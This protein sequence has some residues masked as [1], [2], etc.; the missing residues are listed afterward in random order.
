MRDQEMLRITI[1]ETENE[2]RLVVEGQ[3]T[4]SSVPE[5]ESAWKE[6]RKL[7][8]NCAYVIDLS[9]TTCVDSSGKAALIGMVCDGARLIANG[10][11]TEYV[12]QKLMNQAQDARRRRRDIAGGM[13]S[14][15]GCAG[16]RPPGKEKE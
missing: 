10:L 7:H 9:E 14:V 15:S 3:L 2:Q 6:I 12:I 4:R 13:D 16:Y 11:Y 8:Q 5:L 1:L